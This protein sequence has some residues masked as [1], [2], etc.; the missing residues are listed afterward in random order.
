MIDWLRKLLGT[1]RPLGPR[2]G[3]GLRYTPLIP[4]AAILA[5]AGGAQGPFTQAFFSVVG[6]GLVVAA[7]ALMVGI[8]AGFLFAVPRGPTETSG[9]TLSTNT[10]LDKV[11]DWLTTILVGLGL[12]QLG[13]LDGAFEG[14]SEGI[15]PGLGDGANAETFA[16]GLLIFSLI[17]GFLIGY[18]GTRLVVALRFKEAE[19]KL[20]DTAEV[21]A[22]PEPEPVPGAMQTD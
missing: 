15:A 8:L 4:L 17:D 7:A 22:R 1:N 19:D 13:E 3:M 6:V 20:K 2:V 9:T 18:L 14:L 21:L 10:N 16:L 11:S 5:Y 12:V